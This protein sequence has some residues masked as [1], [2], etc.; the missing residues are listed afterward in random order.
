MSATSLERW[1]KSHTG[2][3][4]S[5]CGTSYHDCNLRIFGGKSACCGTCGYTGTH[6]E[7]TLTQHKIV[8]A[9]SILDFPLA[10]EEDK[11]VTIEGSNPIVNFTLS[12]GDVIRVEHNGD[13]LEVRNLGEMGAIGLGIELVSGNLMKVRP[14]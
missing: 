7:K 13:H 4:C 9:G 2:E 1:E 10:N 8:A 3:S 11:T 14:A 12:T 5:N 6:K